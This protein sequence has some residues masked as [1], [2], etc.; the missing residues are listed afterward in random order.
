MLKD[1]LSSKEL[2]S[3]LGIDIIFI[4][5]AFI[6]SPR[7]MNL[8]NVIWHG[9]INPDEFDHHYNIFI[10]VLIYSI[11]KFIF[12]NN[13]DFNIKRRPY[14]S[15][16][17]LKESSF[18]FGKG[19]RC[20]DLSNIINNR[21]QFDIL[22]DQTSFI[23]DSRRDIFKNS[24][25]YIHNDLYF[26]SLLFPQLEHSLRRIYVHS[27]NLPYHYLCAESWQHYTTIDIILDQ[28]INE[29]E[30]NKIHSTLDNHII[31]AL[32]DLYIYPHG[33]RIRDHISHG[34][35][36]KMIPSIYSDKLLGIIVYLCLQ[37]LSNDELHYKYEIFSHI[38]D[39][40]KGYVPC[41]NI[42]SLIQRNL[43]NIY[44][45]LKELFQQINLLDFQCQ[46]DYDFKRRIDL[47]DVYESIYDINNSLYK[48]CNLKINDLFKLEKLNEYYSLSSHENM[49]ITF[50]KPLFMSQDMNSCLS[51]VYKITSHLIS[52]TDKL[53][54]KFKQQY[55]DI[56]S[57]KASARLQN[58]FYK[59]IG[60]ID[61]Y[62]VYLCTISLYLSLQL[63]NNEIYQ[64][65][66]VLKK[67]SLTV[68][69]IKRSINDNMW[70]PITNL[71]SQSLKNLV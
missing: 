16:S 3:L 59:L 1:L 45:N 39:Y 23:P 67:I 61:I 14:F 27:N 50:I 38:L 25:K 65:K 7:G 28:N 43:F 20:F 36:D 10:I 71:I 12:G 29:N 70:I 2:T 21:D 9:F 11:S 5:N 49:N 37:Y 66:K 64:N 30:P 53:I 52:L 6:G 33:L 46:E 69:K 42:P 48:E 13:N 26:I 60:H 57:N 44:T 32:Y 56:V 17:K 51:M 63:I 68:D 18:N 22:I 19:E 55:E 8:R 47:Y 41:F 34:E 31:A 15:F 35:C 62:F 24:L 58:S 40:Y 4:L 54:S